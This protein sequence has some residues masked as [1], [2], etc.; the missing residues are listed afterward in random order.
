MQ[1]AFWEELRR[2]VVLHRRPGEGFLGFFDTNS[3]LGSV[4]SMSVGGYEATEENYQGQLVHQ[5]L[6]EE[7]LFM[8][9]T[10]AAHCGQRCMGT[11]RDVRGSLHRID[12]V[13]LPE[14]WKVNTGKAYTIDEI[15]LGAGMLEDHRVTAV[16]FFLEVGKRQQTCGRWYC[17]EALRLPSVKE[18]IFKCWQ[19]VPGFPRDWSPE[20]MAKL[21]AKLCRLMLQNFCPPATKVPIKQWITADMKMLLLL[22]DA[23]PYFPTTRE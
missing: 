7:Q 21:F 6:A 4:E 23:V 14:Q 1:C 13:V 17:R 16:D 11:W 20:R 2:E 18:D 9:S 15:S 12:Y 10:F 8:P 22:L 5:F 19:E 3:K